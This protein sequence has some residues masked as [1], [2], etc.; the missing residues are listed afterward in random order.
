MSRDIAKA[1]SLRAVDRQSAGI[2]HRPALEELFP[3]NVKVP[4]PSLVSEPVPLIAALKVEL[5]PA[6]AKNVPPQ[7]FSVIA[8]LDVIP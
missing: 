2:Q 3:V 8:L 4:A 6:S 1:Q 7:L 5:V